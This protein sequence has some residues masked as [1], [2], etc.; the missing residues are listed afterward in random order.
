MLLHPIIFT[1]RV[2]LIDMLLHAMYCTQRVDTF[3]N[4]DT[5]VILADCRNISCLNWDVWD[6]LD[7]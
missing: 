5:R 7:G 2:G 3:M 4:A 6:G 1:Q